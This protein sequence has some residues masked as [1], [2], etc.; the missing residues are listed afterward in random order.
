MTK[1]N[2]K[3]KC[4]STIIITTDMICVVR[5]IYLFGIFQRRIS[6][7]YITQQTAVRWCFRNGLLLLINGFLSLIRFGDDLDELLLGGLQM[8]SDVNV[9]MEY[10]ED[11]LMDISRSNLP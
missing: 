1:I 11:M 5:I 2:M 3:N 7:W 8:R 9:K 4:S 6:L 10:S